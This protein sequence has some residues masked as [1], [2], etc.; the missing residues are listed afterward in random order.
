[1][2]AAVRT[3]ALSGSVHPAAG[4]A[5]Q[6]AEAAALALAMRGAMALGAGGLTLLLA[7]PV[8]LANEIG[9][10]SGAQVMGGCFS[11]GFSRVA[12]VTRE[13]VLL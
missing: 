13:G 9:S 8:A 2:L 5:G 10:G 1:V 7:V 12:D 6:E 11:M 3:T 4:A